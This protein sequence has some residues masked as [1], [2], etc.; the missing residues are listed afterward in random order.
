[1]AHKLLIYCPD[2]D[3]GGAQRT[4][5]NLAAGLSETGRF[6]VELALGAES[7]PAALW[8]P[9]GIHHFTLPPGR[10]RSQVLALRRLILRRS[11]SAVLTTM[12]HGNLTLWL[13]TRGMR[14]RPKIILRETNSHRSRD[15]LSSKQRWLAGLAYR[16]A[17]GFI[18]LSEGVLREMHDLYALDP[19]KTACLPNPIDLDRFRTVGARRPDPQTVDGLSLLSVGRLAS[20]KNH[21]LL[22]HAVASAGQTVRSLTILGEGSLRPEIEALTARLS[23]I[24]KVS[25]PG[26]VAETAPY[27][28]T[29][30]LFVLSSRYE[31]F[32]HVIVEAMAAGVPVIATDCPWGPAEIIEDGVSGIMV[33][34]EDAPA[35]AAAID[36]LASDGALRQRLSE[37]GRARADAFAL[38][39]I[40][41]RY[42]DMIESFIEE[43]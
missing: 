18:A 40:S 2:L 16:S 39:R 6:T 9:E 32:G 5:L 24:D 33:P 36:R 41:R 34:N 42:A 22:L 35:L 43:N 8:L 27:L 4:L 20:Q 38:D 17:D 13:A 3:G 30:D 23:L 25:M 7:G 28:A 1:M 19:A 10:A 26:H 31:G 21:A 14:R 37:G 12:L 11:P 15:D 29:A